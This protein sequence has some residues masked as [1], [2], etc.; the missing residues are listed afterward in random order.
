MKRNL[1]IGLLILLVFTGIVAIGLMLPRRPSNDQALRILITCPTAEHFTCS[2]VANGITNT[3]SAVTPA[4]IG[5]S[6]SDFRY[7]LKPDH[8]REE[9]RVNFEIANVTRMSVLSYKGNPIRGGCRYASDGS[10]SV[11]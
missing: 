3:I 7:E 2:Y 5:A 11:W 4:V 9:F 6:A 10:S 1:I 8:E